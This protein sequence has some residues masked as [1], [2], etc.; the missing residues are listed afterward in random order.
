MPFVAAALASAG[1]PRDMPVH[2]ATST[3]AAGMQ[4]NTDVLP[5]TR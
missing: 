5:V 3:E 2:D 4:P 1:T